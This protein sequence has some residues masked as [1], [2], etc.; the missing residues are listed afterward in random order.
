LIEAGRLNAARFDTESALAAYEKIYK[1]ALAQ[2]IKGRNQLAEAGRANQT[3]PIH[4]PG[5]MQPCELLNGES[6]E[7]NQKLP[8]AKI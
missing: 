4:M 5:T 3:L 6:R 7:L 1:R 2:S 8:A